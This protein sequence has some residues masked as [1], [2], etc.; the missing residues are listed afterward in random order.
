MV[1]QCCFP[2][3]IEDYSTQFIGWVERVRPDRC[4]HCK[5][6]GVCVLWGSYLCWV[7]TTTDKVRIR[8]VRVRCMV[9][10]VTDALL[11]SF[12][13]M[14]RRYT[15]P[16]TRRVRIIQQ[17]LYLVLDKGLW[18]VALVSAVAPYGQPAPSTLAEWVS[19]FVD[20]AQAWLVDWL[21]R[22]LAAL[23]PL[24]LP[25]PGRLPTHINALPSTSSGQAPSP[26]RDKF[27]AGWQALRLTE[28]LYVLTRARQPDLAFRAEVLPAF[29]TAALGSAGRM[30]RILWP[31]TLRV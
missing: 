23:D 8:I 10:K 9:C 1:I 14:Y 29:L 13:H 28:S 24:A 11:P 30:P 21:Q 25:D 12:L 18:G 19:A 5:G 7:Y 3:T 15:L 17:A 22:A 27:S 4:P 20:S 2:C 26:R 6:E 31:Q 16:R